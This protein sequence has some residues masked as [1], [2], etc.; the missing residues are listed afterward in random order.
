MIEIVTD[1]KMCNDNILFDNEA[2][3]FENVSLE[4]DSKYEFVLEG[5]DNA[6]ILDY[7]TGLVQTPFGLTSFEQLSTGCKTVLNY[8]HLRK[9]G[10]RYS[11]LN[12]TECGANALNVLFE[13]CETDDGIG[14][15]LG[16]DENLANI[17]PH[18]FSVNGRLT[19]NLLEGCYGL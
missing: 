5:I 2:Y 10:S 15:Y 9:H 7:D 11:Y 14:F 12:I 13:L 3:F 1:L 19:T 17:G 16:H 4:H 18:E 8:L 6:K